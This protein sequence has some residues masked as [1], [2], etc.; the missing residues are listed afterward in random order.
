VTL[1]LKRLDQ[2]F[3][4]DRAFAPA[5]AALGYA[6][7][8]RA[9]RG[10]APPAEADAA[11]EA[12]ANTA[13]ALDPNLAEAHSVLAQLHVH[14]RE[15]AAAIREFERALELNPGLPST[16]QWLGSGL[17][18]TDTTVPMKEILDL[19]FAVTQLRPTRVTNLVATGSSSTVN[20]MSTVTLSSENDALWDDMAKDGFILEKDIPANAQPGL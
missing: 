6:N 2:V 13:L 1:A 3:A 11:A 14:R 7:L 19:T 20:G 9:S 17:Q 18:Q 16:Y 10:M 8:V 5:W 15:L 12:A 4:L